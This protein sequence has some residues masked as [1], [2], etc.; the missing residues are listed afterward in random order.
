[1]VTPDL[2]NGESGSYTLEPAV[3]SNPSKAGRAMRRRRSRSWAQFDLE[4]KLRPLQ[5]R[6][7]EELLTPRE[8]GAFEGGLGIESGSGGDPGREET[9]S[10][11]ASP[12]YSYSHRRWFPFFGRKS[13]M[14]RKEA[15][16]GRGAPPT[17]ARQA[18]KA[19]SSWRWRNSPADGASATKEAAGDDNN[20]RSGVTTAAES[21]W[22]QRRRRIARHNLSAADDDR[23]R[24]RSRRRP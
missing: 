14:G 3:V 19:G 22:G 20:A 16:E 9:V 10:V 13:N 12:R 7:T 5:V 6:P 1:M 15:A 4:R 24:R 21:G 8:P 11:G 23:R 18:D 17:A 2:V